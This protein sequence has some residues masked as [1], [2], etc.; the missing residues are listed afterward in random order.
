MFRCPVCKGSMETDNPSDADY[1]ALGEVVCS[2]VCHT[3]AYRLHFP[4]EES[5]ERQLSFVFDST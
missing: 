4:E 5:N 3:E 2:Y 1:V